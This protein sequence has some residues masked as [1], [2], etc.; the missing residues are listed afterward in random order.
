MLLGAEGLHVYGY[1][2]GVSSAAE[3]QA[4][5]GTHVSVVAAPGQGNVAV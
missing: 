3:D 5:Q 1:F 4:A 2:Q